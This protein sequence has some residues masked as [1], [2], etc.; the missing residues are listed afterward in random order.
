[1]EMII[2]YGALHIHSTKL[3]EIRSLIVSK[4]ARGLGGGKRIVEF[5]KQE[6]KELGVEE[7]AWF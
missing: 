3:A 1:M 5:C 7:I 6:A 2:G 4:R